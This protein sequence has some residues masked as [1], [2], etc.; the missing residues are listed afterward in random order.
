MSVNIENLVTL[1]IGGDESAFSELVTLFQKPVFYTVYR[2]VRDTGVADDITQE[3]FVKVYKKMKGLKQPS[4]FKSW[5]LRAAMNRAI[6]CKRKMVRE[7][8]KVFLLDDFSVLGTKESS[9]GGTSQDLVEERERFNELQSELSEAIESLPESQKKVL[10]L[11]M[12]DEMAQGEIAQ[13]LGVPGGT[14][15]SRLHHARKHIA[16][17]LKHLLK[18]D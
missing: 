17:R 2:V 14:V 11:S 8:E 6:D 15:K 5:L 18:G 12:N 4:S 9:S 10:L 1:A 7:G 3:I 13:I 16:V